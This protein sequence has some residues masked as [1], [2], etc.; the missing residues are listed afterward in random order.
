MYMLCAQCVFVCVC[1]VCVCV[2][3]I[4][5]LL[6]GYVGLGYTSRMS[7]DRISKKPFAWLAATD[8]ACTRSQ[9]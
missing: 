8:S 2:C 7:G 9:A 4:Y 6:E 5:Y 3:V 1:C